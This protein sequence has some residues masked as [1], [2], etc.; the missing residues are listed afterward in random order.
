MATPE[1]RDLPELTISL[2]PELAQAVASHVASGGYATASELVN[3]ALR[4][5]LDTGGGRPFRR[6]GEGESRVA[7][8]FAATMELF[9]WARSI[10][11]E[12]L[13]R[14]APGLSPSEIE[15]RLTELSDAQEGDDF[16]RA[17]GERLRKLK[18]DERG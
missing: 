18:L 4:Q 9:G 2:T 15:R 7:E 16:L 11:I 8:R 1:S 13:R 3:E 12:K 14:T 10:E 17:S 6:G 5:F